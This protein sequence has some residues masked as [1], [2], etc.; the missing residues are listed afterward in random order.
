MASVICY[1]PHAM[2]NHVATARHRNAPTL[3]VA[4]SISLD[5]SPLGWSCAIG[6]APARGPSRPIFKAT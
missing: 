2:S 5:F 6:P 4:C 1:T 3:P